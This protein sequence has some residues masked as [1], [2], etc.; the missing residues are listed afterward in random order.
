MTAPSWLLAS[1]F[2]FSRLEEMIVL[3]KRLNLK[4]HINI[5]ESNTFQHTKTKAP[6]IKNTKKAWSGCH[7]L[8]IHRLQSKFCLSNPQGKCHSPS[9]SPGVLH[10]QISGPKPDTCTWP[11]SPTRP[12]APK[13]ES[14]QVPPLFGVFFGWNH[15]SRGRSRMH[16]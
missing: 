16:G 14:T 4:H 12:W 9:Q 5:Q 11:S 2:Q 13:M 10:M 8:R 6:K 3:Y 1:S 15:A 7:S